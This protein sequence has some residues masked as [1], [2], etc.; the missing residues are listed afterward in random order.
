MRVC[1]VG[2]GCCDVLCQVGKAR[3]CNVLGHIGKVND[4]DALMNIFFCSLLLDLDIHFFVSFSLPYFILF[5]CGVSARV[6]FFRGCCDVL[7]QICNARYC[8]VLGH[9]GK[10]TKGD[11]SCLNKKNFLAK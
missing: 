5:Y 9:I 2:W 1:L 8:N 11:I 6:Q 10:A 7:G 4:A 3:Y